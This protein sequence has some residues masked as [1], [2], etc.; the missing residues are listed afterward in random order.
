MNNHFKNFLLVFFSILS[1]NVLAQTTGLIFD[2]AAYDKV[3]LKAPLT[4]SFYSVP[5]RASLKKYS[6]TP[7]SQGNYST[8]VG[9]ATAYAAR[10]IAMAEYKGWRNKSTITNNAFSPGFIYRSIQANDYSCQNGSSVLTALKVMKRDGVPKYS[11]FK[12]SCPNRIPNQVYAKASNYRIQDYVRL[13]DIEDRPAQKIAIVKKSISEGKPVIIGMKVPKSFLM[14]YRQELWEPKPNETPWNTHDGHAMTVIA[15]D[16]NKYGG[17]FELQNSWGTNWGNGGYIWIKYQ[18][19]ANFTKYA[20]ELIDKPKPKPSYKPDLSGKMRFLLENGSEMKADFVNGSYIMRRSYASGTR[21]RLYISNNEPA[22][23]YAFGS[24]LTG[25][26]YPIFPHEP[27]ISPALTYKRNEV[28]IPDEDHYIEMDNTVGRD[29]FCVL[30]GKEP[31]DIDE[32]HRRLE[33]INQSRGLFVT[34]AKRKKTQSNFFKNVK[35]VVSTQAVK[36][37]YIRYFKRGIGFSAASHG[38]TLVPLC[39][40]IKHTR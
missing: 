20:F 6:P 16:N 10:T 25:K 36:S 30:Y 12:Q 9:W 1:L 17:A 8:C 5:S 14:V 22:Y 38:K 40:E 13:F 4:R 27:G 23:V 32:I 37:R 35:Q 21:F 15:Y 26:I 29:F 11:A 18:D 31:L 34:P 33:Q 2:D 24:D 39:V 3:L 7:K 19:F 28:P